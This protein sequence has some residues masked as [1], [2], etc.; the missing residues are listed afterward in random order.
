MISADK[1]RPVRID[2]SWKKLTPG[3]LS[4]HQFW[5][6]Q[7]RRCK[8]GFKPFGGTWMPGAYYFYLN[9]S[10]ILAF[11]EKLGRK[12][13]KPPSYRDQDHEYFLEVHKA[14]IGGYGLVVLKARRKGF[15]QPE[16]SLIETPFGKRKMG[17]LKTGD[18]VIGSNGNPTKILATHPQGK[19]K[20][21]EV[22]LR[23][24]RKVK[25]GIN[26]LWSIIDFKGKER[27]VSTKNLISVKLIKNKGQ[28]N[29]YYHCHIPIGKPV[30]YSEKKYSINPY[31]LGYFLGDG[32]ATGS[33]LSITTADKE[34]IDYLNPLIPNNCKIKS[35][36]NLHY[37]ISRKIR[38]TRKNSNPVMKAIRNLGLNCNGKIKFIPKE[39]FYGSVDQRMELLRGLMDSD[40]TSS[41]NG[42]IR[43][44]T[45]SDK[46]KN[47]FERLVSGLGIRFYSSLKKFKNKR[48]CWTISLTTDK[49]VFNLKRKRKNVRTNR[50]YDFN[51]VPII[52]VKDLG[53]EERQKCITV[54]SKD[55]L[56]MAENYVLTHNS[57]MN[58][59]IILC[60]WTLYPQS[61]CGVG[62][63]KE[64]YVS[65]FK[66]KMMMSYYELPPEMQNKTLLNNSDV[67]KSGYREKTDGKWIDKGF[68]SQVYWR[69][70]DK[71]DAFRGVSQTYTII[72][73]AGEVRK[74]KKVYY[75]NEECYREGDIQFG[76]PIIGG[77][78]NQITN[79][80]ED[81]MD[82]YYKPE[83]YNCKSIFIPASKVYHGYFNYKTGESD[84]EGATVAIEKRA[85]KLRNI[86]DKTRFYAFRQE[87]PLKPE[88]AFMQFGLSPFDLDK[89]NNQIA[90]ILTNKALR[91]TR[92]FRLEWPE[93][94]KGKRVFGGK[95]DFVEDN[96]G[97]FKIVDL[98]LDNLKNA[99]VSAVDPYH[100]DDEL[101]D[102]TF[103]S[104]S[105]G[106]MFVYRRFIDMN[107]HGQL[108]V[109]EYFDRPE[110]K[111][112]FY[113]NCL[114]LAI[115]YDTQILVEYNDDGFLKYF[116]DNKM[117]RF[118][119]ERPRAADSPW[120]QVSN[121]YG[122]HMKSFQKK[123]V[124]ELIDEYVKN[125]C[126]EI[127][128]V[129]LLQELAKFGA[130]NTDRAMA[131]GM[132]LLH[133]MDVFRKIVDK[134]KED[135]QETFWMPHVKR[136]STGNLVV[137][138]RG[139]DGKLQSSSRK[140]T[141]DYNFDHDD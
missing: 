66:N 73:E 108:P 29:Q 21:Y 51:K 18:F 109:A 118:L 98:P 63:Q 6:E 115:A 57:F 25:C 112:I 14:K 81:F 130:I 120:S 71:P 134:E 94:G 55:S 89:I 32:S 87:M 11:D 124:I 137:Q 26:H 139:P 90:D 44:I 31:L 70:I 133:D 37:I 12:I 114:K 78:S 42:A 96:Q 35:S 129:E 79:D 102:G 69:V 52:E 99:H 119:K 128:F 92:R 50:K 86:S 30:N 13:M 45:T 74:L 72:E 84:V 140:P 27:I 113:E 56:Y 34:V 88:H 48:D 43:F 80:S 104:D 85:D 127:Y 46:L 15:E 111:S 20:V 103:D 10:K 8:E 61:E 116:I 54:E 132:S 122:V 82:M 93:D 53:F 3:T 106:C 19:K 40:G 95:P 38:T 49:K 16:S 33:T 136:D 105:K 9:F 97:P 65:D 110:S 36:D 107:T 67:F 58:A 24:G 91:I 47:D 141:F 135:K 28:K 68:L 100:I 138:A 7:V 75:A 126:E 39:Y 4:Y 64:N 60:E 121:K 5:N 83:E 77:T 117:S 22:T 41:P 62:S 59:N 1:Y 123:L 101:E 76:V 2:R 125:H 23:D 131:F 17:D